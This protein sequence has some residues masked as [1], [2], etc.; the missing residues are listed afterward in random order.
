MVLV[1]RMGNFCCYVCSNIC[2]QL[3]RNVIFM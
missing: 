2:L 3:K 1:P